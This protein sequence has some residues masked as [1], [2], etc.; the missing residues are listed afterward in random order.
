[1][2]TFYH[3]SDV[4]RFLSLTAACRGD[5]TLLLPNGEARDIKNDQT[6]RQMFRMLPPGMN[7]LAVR[8]DLSDPGD[9]SPFVQY[10]IDMV[11]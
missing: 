6:A 2:I 10:L 5:A 3:I 11:A 9:L 8:L 1:M 4:E 7:R